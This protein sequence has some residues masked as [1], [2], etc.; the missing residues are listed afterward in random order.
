MC[1]A[2]KS[3]YQVCCCCE[4]VYFS[5][6]SGNAYVKLRTRSWFRLKWVLTS[7]MRVKVKVFLPIQLWLLLLHYN[8]AL[9]S[10]VKDCVW[11]T[12]PLN[13]LLTW[14]SIAFYTPTQEGCLKK[15]WRSR[16]IYN[17]IDC[18]ANDRAAIF[19]TLE[20]T[21]SCHQ[22]STPILYKVFEPWTKIKQMKQFLWETIKKNNDTKHFSFFILLEYQHKRVL[23]YLIC[24]PLSHALTWNTSLYQG[25]CWILC[26]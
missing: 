12:D 15:C 25:L 9:V 21:T 7:L 14:M 24:L 22:W 18:R 26:V 10:S 1:K 11:P 4:T 13:C 23:F 2:L 19:E 17:I 5:L 6:D 16:G 8:S 3:S 20:H